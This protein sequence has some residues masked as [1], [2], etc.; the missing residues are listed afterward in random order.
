MPDERIGHVQDMALF[1][2]RHPLDLMQ[3]SCKRVSAAGPLH[4]LAVFIPNSSSVMTWNACDFSKKL[5]SGDQINLVPSPYLREIAEY[6]YQLPPALMSSASARS[7]LPDP[8]DDPLVHAR[9]DGTLPAPTI[10]RD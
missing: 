9:A 2:G 7:N 10:L 8:K 3:P 5:I 4:G 6:S 1:T